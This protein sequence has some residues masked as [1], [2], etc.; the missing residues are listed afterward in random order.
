MVCVVCVCCLHL[1]DP[2]RCTEKDVDG[3]CLMQNGHQGGASGFVRPLLPLPFSCIPTAEY[4]CSAHPVP[5]QFIIYLN[6][7]KAGSA[8]ACPK[9]LWQARSR[10]QTAVPKSLF[11]KYTCWISLIS[12]VSAFGLLLLSYS[13]MAGGWRLDLHCVMPDL[14]SNVSVLNVSTQRIISRVPKERSTLKL[15]T[16][17]SLVSMCIL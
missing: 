12:P 8:N 15:H 4:F 9:K 3:G 14:F 1:T 13:L 17:C 16:L 6:Q 5:E 7:R 11:R 10:T 2:P